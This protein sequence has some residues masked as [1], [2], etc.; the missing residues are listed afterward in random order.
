MPFT[1]NELKWI[2]WAISADL[3]DN[4]FNIEPAF[5]KEIFDGD[6]EIGAEDLL[7]KLVEPPTNWDT[8]LKEA[9]KQGQETEKFLTTLQITINKNN[10]LICKLC[11]CID[12]AYHFDID[13]EIKCPECGSLL[14][15]EMKDNDMFPPEKEE[16]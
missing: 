14:V 11:K 1:D 4:K 6:N 5:L 13:G 3:N 9:I 8:Y 7:Q 15:E 2:A 10:Y 16:I 12:Q